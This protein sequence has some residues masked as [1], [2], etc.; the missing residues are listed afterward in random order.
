MKS[1][2]A[3]TFAAPRNIRA[4][5]SSLTLLAVFSTQLP[6]ADAAGV[7]LGTVSSADTR[8]ML[9][10]ATVQLPQLNRRVVTDN[11]GRFILRD[12]PVGPVTLV[13]SYTGFADESRTVEV[14]VTGPLA[15]SIEL[16]TSTIMRMDAFTVSSEREGNALALT[17][18]RNAG[19]VK[20]VV[21]MD[22][23]GDIAFANV[24]D[25]AAKL[26]GVMAIPDEEG[27]TAN[28]SIR[29]MAAGLTRLTVDG[30][31]LATVGSR[32]PHMTSQTGALYEQLELIKG[33]LPDRS[34]DSIGG[35]INLKT[36]SALAMKEK[37][38]FD[39]SFSARWAPEFLEQTQARLEHP[40]HPIIK[41]GYQEVFGVGRGE[42]NLGVALNLYYSENATSRNSYTYD[43]QNT[44]ATPAYVYSFIAET[45][46]QN[47]R[48]LSGNLALDYRLSDVS[49]FFLRATWTQNDEPG[50]DR[51]LVTLSATQSVATTDAN[52]QPTGAGVILPDFTHSRTSTRP[53]NGSTVTLETRHHSFHIRTPAINVGGEHD[54]ERWKFEYNVSHSGNE[55]ISMHGNKNP[56]ARGGM[57]SMQ[58]IGVGWE[59]TYAN[60]ERP[61]VRQLAGPDIFDVTK[62]QN[63]VI[64]PRWTETDKTA[65]VLNADIAYTPAAPFPLTFKMG[66]RLGRNTQ[67][68]D[69]APFRAQFVG[70]NAR[71]PV[72][73]SVPQQFEV[74]TG[75][76]FPFLN[77]QLAYKQVLNDP[78][79]WTL[80]E[81][82]RVQQYYMLKNEVQE[83]TSAAYFMARAQP[84]KRFS[85][86][87]GVRGEKTEVESSGYGR[88]Q[89]L[90]TLAQ[91]PD[92][93]QRAEHD[94]NNPLANSGSYTRWFPSVHLSYDVTPNL[95]AMGSWSTSY[96]R[97]DFS[98][99]APGL[100]VNDS[101]GTVTINNPGVG[102]QYS[103]NIDMA[104]QYYLKPA[105]ILSVGYFHKDI[106][107]YIAT[108]NAGTVGSGPSN[109]Y[110]G[111]YAG[112]D[113]ITRR[114]IGFAKVE[115][116]EAEY[117]QQ[118]AMLPGWLKGF[119]TS[120]AY[121]WL[122]SEGNYGGASVMSSNQI[123]SF[124]PRSYNASVGY[125]RGAFG[126]RVLM[127]YQSNYLN[128]FSTN[129][130]RRQ[131]NQSRTIWDV[132][133]SYRWKRGVTVFVN[134]NNLTNEPE[135][136]YRHIS[137][138]PSRIRYFGGTILL[139]INGRL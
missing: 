19:N 32:S 2:L 21:A 11:T 80:D 110:D 42:R 34:A 86:I 99:L 57:I 69:A 102:P 28:V 87:T 104:L 128:A 46:Q 94:Y 43:Y 12:L 91:I 26:P 111:D 138:Q 117:R 38:R 79:L 54:F 127:S 125:T 6:A 14:P 88:R 136:L 129:V 82:Y 29:G 72:G 20:N 40:V 53:L 56:D 37:R 48:V 44:I 66:A 3:S 24:G 70:N 119:D 7:I 139:G 126:I 95:K 135:I 107:D 131:Y 25:I 58:A 27:N 68:A 132:Q 60:P 92:P 123:A 120:V 103:K 96:G 113:V 5:A 39:Y 23:F 76:K 16:Q 52:G 65:S 22:A 97:P 130:A 49:K 9:Q 101:A 115:G 36:R 62:Y 63:A 124:I 83:D 85:V 61:Y 114:N 55:S 35:M 90:A 41:V 18:Q 1:L 105:G 77:P 93:A 17:E 10:G 31:P 33:Q 74:E 59:L 133:T 109:G 67:E 89:T 75:L 8:N 112:Y 84:L 121:T 108:F 47:R 137:S 45:T 51:A 4:L 78:S 116:W 98:L 13:V 30:M 15:V 122:K 134:V 81:Y 100:T 73:I 50:F 64:S 118:F 106:E 71:L